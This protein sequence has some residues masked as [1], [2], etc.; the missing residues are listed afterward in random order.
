VT[1]T[2]TCDF[3]LSMLSSEMCYCDV[4]KLNWKVAFEGLNAFS[5]GF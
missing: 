4:G 5:C 1:E 3:C 2:A